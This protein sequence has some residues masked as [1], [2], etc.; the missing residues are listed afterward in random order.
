[1]LLPADNEGPLA[2]TRA[3]GVSLEP[4]AEAKPPS[5]AAGSLLGGTVEG[6]KGP[7][8]E[9]GLMATGNRSDGADSGAKVN[10]PGV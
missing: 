9:S 7:G 2:G 10:G 6:C 1:M 8:A 3:A 5:D 4:S